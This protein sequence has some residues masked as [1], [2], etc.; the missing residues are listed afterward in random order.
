MFRCSKPF[1]FHEWDRWKTTER[2]QLLRSTPYLTYLNPSR[3]EETKVHVGSYE[4]QRRECKDCGAVQL[5]TVK[6]G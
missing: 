2:G 1:K 6:T 5:R 4:Y 3:V